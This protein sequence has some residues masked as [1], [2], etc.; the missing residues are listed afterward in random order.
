MNKRS[1]GILAIAFFL[2]GLASPASADLSYSYFELSGIPLLDNTQQDPV[3]DGDVPLDGSSVG[4]TLSIA[5]HNNWHLI[6]TANNEFQRSSNFLGLNH[7]GIQNDL[8]ADRT[9]A[10]FVPH[11]NY[12]VFDGDAGRPQIDVFAGLG[13]QYA[14]VEARLNVDGD[15]SKNVAT[16]F[17]VLVR[18][19]ARALVWRELELF[20]DFTGSNIG[21]TRNELFFNLGARYHFLADR[22]DLGI[23]VG[24]GTNDF[25]GLNLSG[26]IYYAEVWRQLFAD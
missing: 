8:D 13:V 23:G 12:R 10:S 17:G 2:L 4:G 25:V 7:L 18:A 1:H 3:G 11:F 16:E 5:V 15:R 9:V 26:R 14:R 6:L 20:G 24:V 21:I 22:V 19:G